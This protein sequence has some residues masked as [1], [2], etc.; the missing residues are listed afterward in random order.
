MTKVPLLAN[1]TDTVL[2]TVHANRF[3]IWVA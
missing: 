3:G 1:I 2:F